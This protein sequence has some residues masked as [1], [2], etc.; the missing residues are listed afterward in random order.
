MAEPAREELTPSATIVV[1]S[2]RFGTYEVPAERIVT[3]PAGLIGFPEACRFALLEPNRPH[4]P[5]RYLICVDLPEL[6]FV[7]CNPHDFWPGFVAEVP[8]PLD[9]QGDVAV[10]VL[11]TIPNNPREM[12]ANLMAPIVIDCESRRGAQLVLDTGRYS[13][14]HP[15][16]PAAPP[17]HQG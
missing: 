14:R 11:V 10:L 3:F 13:T 6:A 2:R 16:L 17:E 7:V 8:R 4:S 5:F 1:R 15:L 12:T 9:V